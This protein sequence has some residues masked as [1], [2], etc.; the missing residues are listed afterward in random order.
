MDIIDGKNLEHVM[1]IGS[2]YNMDSVRVFI[3]GNEYR[4]KAKLLSG[5]LAEFKFTTKKA[6]KH[7]YLTP[8][9]DGIH[10]SIY[11]DDDVN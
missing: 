2:M 10:N 9:L 5:V 8:I 1:T 3:D 4:L 6:R 11:I 7:T